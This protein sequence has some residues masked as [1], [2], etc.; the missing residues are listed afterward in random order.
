MLIGGPS[1]AVDPNGE[2][3]RRDD[4][5]VGARHPRRQGRN[6]CAPSVPGLPARPRAPLRR[7][8][9]RDRR[10]RRVASPRRAGSGPVRR[11]SRR[12]RRATRTHRVPSRRG[13]RPQCRR[14]SRTR[15]RGS[16][17]TPWRGSTIV[18]PSVPPRLW[19][20]RSRSRR[21]AEPAGPETEYAN[22]TGGVN[23][24]TGSTTCRFA[25]SASP[26]AS[27]PGSA[28]VG[29]GSRRG[30][31][32]V[33]GAVDGSAVADGVAVGVGAPSPT[34]GSVGFR[35]E[36]KRPSR[37][38]ARMVPITAAIEMSESRVG[39]D[40]TGR[41]DA[42]L[43]VSEGDATGSAHL[44]P[45]GVRAAAVE[46]VDGLVGHRG[47]A[48]ELLDW[49]RVAAKPSTQVAAGGE[50]ADG[51][52]ADPATGRPRTSLAGATGVA[53]RA[54]KRR[55]GL[56]RPRCCYR[57]PIARTTTSHPETSRS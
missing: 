26:K 33:G 18:S 41:H 53:R 3:P 23:V 11:G 2:T 44:R 19:R 43:A 37:T 48:T 25:S 39:G 47:M 13:S 36:M 57:S 46:A 9:G 1:V 24:S 40:A 29:D 6:R 32:D 30:R 5:H 28:G 56:D 20:P 34:V 51:R 10:H 49:F 22:A 45:L 54:P 8:L 50:N 14:R 38:A 7:C 31:I 17:R 21:D 16:T 4:R 12:R 55:S 35:L 27:V 42:R 15:S 52:V